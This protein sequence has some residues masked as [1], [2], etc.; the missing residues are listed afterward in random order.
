TTAVSLTPCM[1]KVNAAAAKAMYGAMVSE[2]E[3]VKKHGACPT[4]KKTVTAYY[5]DHFTRGIVA[6]LA[7]PKEME[8]LPQASAQIQADLKEK[9]AGEIPFPGKGA[10]FEHHSG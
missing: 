2:E 6:M 4:C 3:G 7:G 1:H 10:I 9:I 5:D 8:M